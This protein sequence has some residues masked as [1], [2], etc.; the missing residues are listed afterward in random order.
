MLDPLTSS[1]LVALAQEIARIGIPKLLGL[2]GRQ[3]AVLG[4]RGPYTTRLRVT[5]QAS[6]GAVPYWML[7]AMQ[8]ADG[9]RVVEV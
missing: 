9:V 3:P 7:F 2:A 5:F 6:T 8:R 1:L 4:V